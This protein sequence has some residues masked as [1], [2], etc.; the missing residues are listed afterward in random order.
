[1]V[2]KHEEALGGFG[3]GTVCLPGTCGQQ[4]F[5]CFQCS[6]QQTTFC[7]KPEILFMPMWV[8]GMNGC[9]L[10]GNK[11]THMGHFRLAFSNPVLG[12]Y[13]RVHVFCSRYGAG[14]A[15]KRGF[16]G[17]EARW[18]KHAGSW[19]TGLVLAIAH[20]AVCLLD[21]DTGPR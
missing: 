7:I 14:R 20:S 16:C 11:I 3:P 13:K 18:S 2:W 1:M 12:D 10:G 4:G 21:T 8:E 15:N 6:Q 5:P 9:S 17:T 19:R